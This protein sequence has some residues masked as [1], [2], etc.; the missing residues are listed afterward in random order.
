MG[1]PIWRLDD[2]ESP[3]V[4]FSVEGGEEGLDP[5][6]DTLFACFERLR[7]YSRVAVVLDLSRAGPDA[8]RR[9]RFVAWLKDNTDWLAPRVIAAAAV[10]PTGIQQRVVTAVLWF[11]EMPCPFKAFSDRES[12]LGWTRG[13]TD[14]EEAG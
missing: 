2:T 7:N 1:T 11:V 4:I 8:R 12:A 3:V 10:T 14:L 6:P 13:F 9:K 5:D